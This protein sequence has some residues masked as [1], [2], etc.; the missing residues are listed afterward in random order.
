RNIEGNDKL[1]DPFDRGFHEAL[2][3][4]I[5]RRRESAGD[6]WCIGYFVDNELKWGRDIA[7]A[8]LVAEAPPDQAAKQELA[9]QLRA[10]YDTIDA[11]NAAW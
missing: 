1:P 2:R 4:R 6:P 3:E 10:K 9:K 8:M 7:A 5:G 11:L